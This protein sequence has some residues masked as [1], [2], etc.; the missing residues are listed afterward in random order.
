MKLKSMLFGFATA[1]TLSL[2]SHTI[3]S[4]GSNTMLITCVDQSESKV[5]WSDRASNPRVQNAL[6]TRCLYEGGFPEVRFITY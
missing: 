5:L 6:L 3:A 1:A 4:I 2:S